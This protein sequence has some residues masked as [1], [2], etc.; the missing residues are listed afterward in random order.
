MKKGIIGLLGAA[1]G[2][3]GAFA[4]TT[5]MSGKVSREQA[6]KTEKFRTYYNVLNQWLLLKQE[7]RT[8]E[9]YFQNADYH[10]I[11]IYGMG[12]MGNRLLKELEGSSVLVKYCMNS[13]VPTMDAELNVV[14][15][16]SM[17]EDVDAI[18]VTAMFAFDEIEERLSE[19]FD[20]PIIS[21]EEVVFGV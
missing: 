11:I 12:E 10:T 2:A 8:I 21:L 16:E 19:D 6:K 18:V 3:A 13:D 4:V 17:L 5:N 7:G 14:E 9:S 15:D 1:A 20:C